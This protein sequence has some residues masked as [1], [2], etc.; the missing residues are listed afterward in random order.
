MFVHLNVGLAWV[1]DST[2]TEFST[3]SVSYVHFIIKTHSSPLISFG[4][5]GSNAIHK[6]LPLNASYSAYG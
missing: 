4:E 6:Y 1:N 2:I 3:S 5:D